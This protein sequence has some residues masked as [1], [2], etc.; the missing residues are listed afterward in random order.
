M[1]VQKFSN[2]NCEIPC[3]SYNFIGAFQYLGELCGELSAD[4]YAEYMD[5]IILSVICYCNEC[6]MLHI[7]M[8]F[9]MCA[10]MFN[11]MCY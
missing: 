2:N 10:V 5:K 3:L 4:V 1:N 6:K 9:G 7:K 11:K 8:Y